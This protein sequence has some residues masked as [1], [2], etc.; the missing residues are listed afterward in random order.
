M[1]DVDYS[2]MYIA[3]MVY[4]QMTMVPVCILASITLILTFRWI[5]FF[6]AFTFIFAYMCVMLMVEFIMGMFHHKGKTII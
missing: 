2:S 4:G 5:H 3:W 6:T 1:R